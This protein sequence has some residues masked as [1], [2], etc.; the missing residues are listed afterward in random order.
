MAGF[1]IKTTLEAI[2]SHINT[3]G[4]VSQVIIG[5][6]TSPPV[7]SGIGIAASLL[8]LREETVLAFGA[9]TREVHT[10]LLRLYRDWLVQPPEM[11]IYPLDE[12]K[13][14]IV[15]NLK[16]DFNL[17]SQVMTLD[18][19]GMHS[20]GYTAEWGRVDIGN[21]AFRIIDMTLP[22]IVDDST[23]LSE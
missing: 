9:T 11:A 16:G 18:F 22:I 14:N 8:P 2:Q 3:T 21:N 20:S 6:Y 19:A 5:D 4:F 1:A 12:C 10:I 7:A 15:A 13:S 17:E 23:A